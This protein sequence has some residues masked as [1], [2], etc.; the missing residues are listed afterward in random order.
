METMQIR[1]GGSPMNALVYVA[2]GAEAH[3]AV[4]LLHGFPGNERNLDLAQDMRRTGW[5]VLYFNYRGSWGSPGDFSF[6]HGIDDVGAVIEYLR[7]PENAKRLRLDPSRI[8]LVGHSM[9]GFMAV[10]AAAADPAI[11]GVAMISAA[12]MSGT[13]EQ[14]Q[15]HDSREV[16]IKKMGTMLAN[17]GM[18]PLSGCTPTGLA[19][20]LSDHASAWGFRS[21]AE[22]IKSRPVLVVTSDDGLA[23][24]NGAFVTALRQAGDARVTALHLA[25]DHAYSDKRIELSQ[26][27]LRWLA[28]LH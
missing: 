10:Q 7:K 8:V 21:K 13:M 12:D 11:K 5:D 22:A 1:S 14:M 23:A 15:A 17:E 9:G 2:A 26:A 28:T 3:P 27:L 25:T 6:S 16:A 18:A 20:E 19:Q 4:I 24:A